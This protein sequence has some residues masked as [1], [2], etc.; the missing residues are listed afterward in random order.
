MDKAKPTNKKLLLIISA[1]SFLITFKL[2]QA[3]IQF[4]NW[5]GFYWSVLHVIIVATGSYLALRPKTK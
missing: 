1:I 2:A 5:P 4:N 3:A